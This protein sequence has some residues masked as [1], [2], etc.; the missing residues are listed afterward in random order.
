[1]K[2]Q[3]LNFQANIGAVHTASKNSKPAKTLGTGTIKFGDLELQAVWAPTFSKNLV[4]GIQIMNQGHS[5][6]ISNGV[7]VISDAVTLPPSSKI[8]ATGRLDST[9]G[10]MKMDEG[11]DFKAAAQFKLPL[12]NQYSLL[13]TQFEVPE[14]SDEVKSIGSEPGTLPIS[15]SHEGNFIGLADTANYSNSKSI[16]ISD[17]T[18]M[19]QRFGHPGSAVLENS[20]KAVKGIKV[21]GEPPLILCEPCQLGKMRRPNISKKGSQAKDLLQIISG[22]VQGPFRVPASDGTKYNIK[23]IDQKSRY[24]HMETISTPSA[25]VALDSFKPFL[26]QI[27]KDTKKENKIFRCDG[28]GEFKGVFGSFL[29]DQGTV[30][31]IG[32]AYEHH[33]PGQAEN[34]H[35]SIMNKGRTCLIASNLPLDQYANAQ[36]YSAYMHNRTVHS[37]D[38]IT[39]YE[40][41][42]HEAPTLNHIHQ[43]GCVGYAFLPPEVRDRPTMLG[44]LEPSAVKC[45]L[46][47]YGDEDG[48]VQMAGYKILVENNGDPYETISKSVRFDDHAPMLPLPDSVPFDPSHDEDLF[49]DPTFVPEI[50]AE[51][52]PV[53]ENEPVAIED[54]NDLD[55]L[56]N[57]LSAKMKVELTSIIDEHYSHLWQQPKFKHLDSEALMY[58]FLAMTDGVAT[59]LSRKE[60]MAG[61]EAA[62]WLAAEKIE[63][64]KMHKTGT[65]ELI[66]RPSGVNVIKS[67]WVYRK[68]LNSKGEVI[69]F[70]ARLVAK[71]FTQVEGVDFKE[72]FAPVAKM[73][74]IRAVCAIAAAKGMK[75]F[76]AD[77]PHAFLWPYLKEEIYMEQAA[78]H[79]VGSKICKLRRTL[80]GL[81]QSPRE[82]NMLMD[83]Y[84]RKEG[85][86]PTISDTCI[87]I[88]H[89]ANGDI[90]IVAVYV[91]DLFIAG[92]IDSTLTAFLAKL[93]KDFDMKPI[94]LLEWY[95]GCRFQQLE[96][97]TIIMDQET[98]LRQKLQEFEEWIGIEQRASPLPPNW[99]EILLEE[100]KPADKNF[101]YR[102]MLGSLMYAMVSSRPDLA[103]P[104]SLLSQFLAAP[105]EKHCS[106]LKHVFHYIRSNVDYS[107]TFEG[108][109]DAIIMLEGHV[110]AGYGNNIECR[111]TSGFCFTIG[112]SLVSWYSKKQGCVAQSACESEYIS[113]AEAAKECLWFKNLLGEIGFKQGCIKMYED[114]QACIALSKNPQNHNRTKHIQL[115]YHFIRDCV[116][117]GE[118]DLLWVPTKEQL[119]DLFTKG[120]PG[121][122][123]RPLLSRLGVKRLLRQG[124]S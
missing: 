88:K 85:F 62:K 71:G 108:S 110:D 2:D 79:E 111:S 26:L 65:W 46:I 16:S 83:D 28:G 63:L 35:R 55:P 102:S 104:V 49:G 77:V 44:K 64:A 4:S 11:I 120:L 17:H 53:V 56:T 87:Y 23:F 98:Y 19:H 66:E 100:S 22:D 118:I 105:L 43:F 124:E 82:F 45:R 86:V 109:K 112:G 75:V 76:Q 95:L 69:E 89:L 93:Q 116:Q 1:M 14:K 12:Q 37:G 30:K 18:I 8:L 67:R 33:F 61:P 78:G 60:A 7:L 27:Q 73:K 25:K 59:P 121:H 92:K 41:R 42:H 91:D 47:G 3:P 13:S 58:A 90:Q 74:S 21:S 81:K 97:G 6:I 119:A 114:N 51:E 57:A 29:M 36:L 122:V 15:P 107:L 123:L 72:T 5:A 50:E 20:L 34:I 10:L 9:S 84:L 113:A 48:A 103:F 94:G 31:Q 40:H 54:D 80:Y 32:D 96:D 106:L 101:P 115:I 68:K 39:P 38:T 99:T 70:K 24:L 52:D 117:K